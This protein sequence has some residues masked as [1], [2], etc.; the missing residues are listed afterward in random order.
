VAVSG[1]KILS[2]IAE[3]DQI[4]MISDKPR[5]LRP[6]DCVT[7]A[8]PVTNSFMGSIRDTHQ[9]NTMSTRLK[10]NA[11]RI[12]HNKDLAAAVTSNF[13]SEPS[14]TSVEI[15][16]KNGFANPYAAHDN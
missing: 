1:E 13:D 6:S 11:N 8:D 3:E 9:T 2:E 14:A 5:R 15:G 4:S 7:P 16:G 10:E 12:L